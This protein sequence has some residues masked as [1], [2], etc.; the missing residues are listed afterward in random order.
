[1][2]VD[3]GSFPLPQ[4]RQETSRFLACCI[5]L[6]QRVAMDDLASHFVEERSKVR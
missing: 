2:A 1:M 6:S 3:N 5:W 4:T